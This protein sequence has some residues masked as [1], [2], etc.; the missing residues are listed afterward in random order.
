MTLFTRMSVFTLAAALSLA[1][2][3]EPVQFDRFFAPRTMRV[4]YLHTGGSEPERLT[5]D[6]VSDDGGW[7]G[8]RTILVD[9]TN[10]GDFLFEVFDRATNTLIYSRGFGSIYGEWTT[11]AEF[12]TRRR[13][14]HE[15][16]RF[17]WPKAPVRIVLKRRGAENAFEPFWSTVIDPR[18]EAVVQIRPEVP[19][20][21]WT[22][23]QSGTPSSKVD[24]LLIGVGY[25]EAEIP[26]FHGDA[27]RLVAGLF[28]R[29]PFKSRRSDFNVRAID[30]PMERSALTAEYN[31]FGLARYLLSYDNRALRDIGASVPNDVVELL[32]NS[33]EYGGGGIYN[34]QGTVAVDNAS[35]DYVFAH[36][37]AH[38]FAALG[39]EYTGNVTY[40]AR[41]TNQTEPWEPNLTVLKPGVPLKWRDLVEPGT[42]I[43]TPLEFAGKVGAFEGGRYQTRGI[44]RPEAACLMGSSTTESLCRVCQRA[45]NR[46]IDMYVK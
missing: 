24:V 20:R 23:F 13:T 19:S 28:S 37:F 39:D 46:I 44:F 21:A 40:E 33:H 35:A 32:V 1:A 26:K 2:A 5:L 9:D 14:F 16:L 45:V 30:L 4:D 29:E 34:A 27:A 17:P 8:S 25:R 11:T 41:T 36:E 31:V 42:P 7:A 22:L 43:P 38:N 6:R 12:R 15:S 18:Q 10:L 3:D